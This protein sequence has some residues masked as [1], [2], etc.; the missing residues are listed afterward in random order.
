MFLA[1]L[2]V[3]LRPPTC[4]GELW[5][6][7]CFVFCLND[8]W[9]GLKDYLDFFVIPLII[10]FIICGQCLLSIIDV[11]QRYFRLLF[12]SLILR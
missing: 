6:R 10:K 2:F 8:D 12:P 4:W 11:L 1:K 3:P 7:L 5:R 9:G